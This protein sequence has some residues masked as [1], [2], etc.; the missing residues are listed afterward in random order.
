M[1]IV[2]SAV[3]GFGARLLC[4]PLDTIKTVSFT[5]FAGDAYSPS[6]R[7]SFLSSAQAIWKSEGLRGLYRGVGIAAVGSAPGVALYLTTYNWCNDGWQQLGKLESPPS[8]GLSS[9]SYAAAATPSAIRYFA[10]GLLAEAVSCLVWVPIDVVKERLQS[11]PPSLLHRYRSSADGIGRILHSEGWRGLYKG[12]GSTLASFGPFSAVYFVF[13]EAFSHQLRYRLTP[14]S[15]SMPSSSTTQPLAEAGTAIQ[16]SATSSFLVALI[17]GAGG[18]VVASLCTNPLELVKTRLQV[19]RAVLS[20]QHHS[21]RSTQSSCSSGAATMTASTP[22]LFHFDYRNLMDGLS[23]VAK[24]EG[25]LALWKGVGSRIAFTA[26][27][28]A[29]TMGLFEYLRSTFA[30]SSPLA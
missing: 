8:T 24:T 23:T 27:N 28:A 12:Y 6:S 13:Y 14:S 30:T 20:Y 1:D 29:L 26:P 3:A 21:T 2:Y 7:G 17:A 15:S 25:V 4:H 5:G 9:L 19:Q 18:N 16:L 22:R 10:C 11:Q